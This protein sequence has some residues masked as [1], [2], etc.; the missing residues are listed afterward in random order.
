[1]KKSAICA[2]LAIVFMGLTVIGCDALRRTVEIPDLTKST[3][4]NA[5]VSTEKRGLLIYVVDEIES[6]EVEKG[7]IAKQEP[8][9]L[10][11]VKRGSSVKVWISKG[12]VMVE[13]P[14]L[15][16]VAASAARAKLNKLGLEVDE[17]EVYSEEIPKDFVVSSDPSPGMMVQKGATVNLKVS[18][19]PEPPKTAVVPNV[20][21]MGK[22]AAQKKIEEA[23]LEAKFVY[24][25]STEYYEGTLYYQSPK[26]G[27]VVPIGSTVTA[28]IA[29]VLD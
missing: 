21:R 17:E 6:D 23:G 15:E 24:R 9:P 27:S 26:A 5:K 8:L 14:A 4:E 28:Y 29:T 18:M 19:G 2:L 16:N 3:V 13:V 20:I 7:L 12:L 1:M 22:S 25:V 11:E 10:S